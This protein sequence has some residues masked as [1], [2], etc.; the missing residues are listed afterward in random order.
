MINRSTEPQV[1]GGEPGDANRAPLP[2][3]ERRRS[4]SLNECGAVLL[5]RPVFH[6][7]SLAA[8]P[9]GLVLPPGGWGV[10]GAL[11]TAAG[12][13]QGG[14]SDQ[15]A[16]VRCC[17]GA[18]RYSLGLLVLSDVMTNTQGQPEAGA[19]TQGGSH[20]AGTVPAILPP[21]TG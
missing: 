19:T 7:F 2:I 13:L 1:R 14:S 16:R 3:S 10:G 4:L 6:C 15:N 8:V 9:F 17:H 20:S 5:L 18:P 21:F 11:C 12:L